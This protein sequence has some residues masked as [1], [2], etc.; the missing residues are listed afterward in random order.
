MRDLWDE[1]KTWPEFGFFL[2]SLYA[3]SVLVWFIF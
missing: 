1:M 3:T 2:G